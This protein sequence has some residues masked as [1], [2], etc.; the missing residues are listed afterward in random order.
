MN[1]R[2]NRAGGAAV[3]YRTRRC[4]G[5]LLPALGEGKTI[6]I[7]FGSPNISK[8]LAYHH[9]RSTTIGHA[10]AQIFRG[11]GYRVIAI[12]HLGDWGTTHG[13][14]IAAA[15]KW[16]ITEPLDVAQLNALYVRFTNAKNEDPSLEQAARDWFKK[17]EDGDPEATAL[18]QR[19]RDV[20]WAEFQTIYE[21]LGIH[22][23]EVRGESAY[24]AGSAARDGGAARQGARRRERR[25]A[26]RVPRLPNEKTPILLITKG[27]GT[28]LYATRDVA[29]AEYRW[30][31][32]HPA[33]SLYVVD[34]GQALHF[35]QLFKLLA[36]MGYAWA[37]VCEHVPF[38][39]VRVGGKKTS[40][41]LGNVVLMR[42]VFAIAEDEVRAIVTE[43]N[44]ELPADA[45]AKVARDV[46]IG[47][48]VVAN[49]A[50]QRDKDLDFD[51]EKAAS[52][53]GD[54]GPYLQYSHAR[55]ASIMRKAGESVTSIAGVDFTRL[56]NPALLATELGDRRAQFADAEWGVARRLLEFADVV[57][58]AGNACEPHIVCHYLLEL[59]GDFSRWYTFGNADASLRVLVRRSADS[60]R[61]TRARRE[62]SRRCCAHGPGDARPRGAGSDVA[63]GRLA[64]IVRV[65]RTSWT[66]RCEVFTRLRGHGGCSSPRARYDG[67]AMDEHPN[68]VST[69]DDLASLPED[70]RYEILDGELFGEPVA[71]DGAPAR[72]QAPRAGV[73][74][75]RAAQGRVDLVRAVRRDLVADARGS[76]P[77][78]SAA[79]RKE[80]RSWIIT[81][82]AVEAGARSGARGAVAVE[83]L[84]HVIGRASDESGRA[85]RRAASTGSSIPTPDRSRS[86]S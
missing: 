2:A 24:D 5:T 54:S 27:D 42:D 49:L 61:S 33:R 76:S 74:R 15:K 68:K 86:S 71:V 23:D 52:L 62:R 20:S 65:P 26:G 34:S 55:C 45:V 40:T 9:I 3:D 60:R 57:V 56:A 85:Q 77:T 50:P 16:G 84:K 36:L 38:G 18:W 48:V 31:T 75:A 11:L 1:F 59:A 43:A 67:G 6:C 39:L 41:R 81:K 21:V 4:D 7:D 82:R 28:T 22:Y 47:A 69:Y 70:Q 13:A 17:I 64:A 78:C 53:S 29:A 72:T 32:Y 14:L 46:G 8:H 44:P 37:S 66:S 10:L 79:I 25:R 73:R 19:F 51:L 35:R 80:R 30:N 12:N 58:R 83:H 63:S